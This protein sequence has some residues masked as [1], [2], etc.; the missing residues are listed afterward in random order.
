M[1]LTGDLKREHEWLRQKLDLF[2]GVLTTSP[3]PVTIRGM[4]HTLARML[5]QHVRN[6]DR[7]AAP[8]TNRLQSIFRNRLLDDHADERALVRDFNDLV[9][10]GISIPT[11]RAVLHLFRLINELREHMAMEERELFP[12]LDYAQTHPALAEDAEVSP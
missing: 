2:E 9:A 3:S 5:E 6:E 7:V 10:A 12:S 1:T 4:C 8:Y 11:G